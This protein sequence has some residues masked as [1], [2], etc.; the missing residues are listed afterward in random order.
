M[1]T[2]KAYH[3]VH[4]VWSF[5]WCTRYHSHSPLPPRCMPLYRIINPCSN[6]KPGGISAHGISHLV[7]LNFYL[8]NSFWNRLLKSIL[9]HNALNLS[10]T[11][12]LELFLFLLSSFFPTIESISLIF[13]LSQIEFLSHF[14]NYFFICRICINIGLAPSNPCSF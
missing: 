13:F 1:Y 4:Y 2:K 10:T 3:W 8:W 5:Q 6:T 11:R 12:G 9:F 14:S 7:F